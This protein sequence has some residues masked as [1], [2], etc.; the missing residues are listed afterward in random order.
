MNAI[1]LTTSLHVL[2][3]GGKTG[4][5]LLNS[6]TLLVNNL[7]SPPTIKPE[8]NQ[9]TLLKCIIIWETTS[10]L[11][12][13]P[14]INYTCAYWKED[15]KALEDAQI[16]KMDLVARKLNLKPGMKILGFRLWL[17]C[18]GKVFGPNYEVSVTCYNI[19]TEQVKY[20]KKSCRGLDVTFIVE[21]YRN[22]TGQYD[23]VYSIGIF[24]H[25]GLQNFRD[26]F[27]VVHRCLK[28]DRLTLL[29][30]ITTNGSA[31]FRVRDPRWTT[32]YIFPGGELPF[33]SDMLNFSEDLFT[34]EDVQ[35]LGKS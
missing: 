7:P 1:T 20:A 26:Y 29:H 13:G 6:T 12:L 35:S 21:D 25:V 18:H 11:M 15:T 28:D 17:R 3:M 31:P 10:K 14:S 19:S 2:Q 5:V 4:I 8:R 32:K 34:V 16:N 9:L 27:Q 24:E 30:S 23:R 22:A 33:V